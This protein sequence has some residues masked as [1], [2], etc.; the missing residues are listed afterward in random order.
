M[1]FNDGYDTIIGEKGSS[2]S[3]GQKQR[4]CIARAILKK[5]K[6]LIFD[7]ATSALDLNTEARLYKA[8]KEYMSDVTIILIAQRVAS[9]KGAEKIMVIDDGEIK[10]IGANDELLK[11][12]EVYQD[13]YYSQLKANGGE[14]DE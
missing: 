12:N 1:S 3:G 13:I 6:I 14:D 10:G 9:A 8:L 4:V 11:T 7:D 2:L 5:P